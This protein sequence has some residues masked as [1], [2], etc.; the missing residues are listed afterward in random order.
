MS[1]LARLEKL[2]D[3]PARMTSDVAAIYMGISE[4]TSGRASARSA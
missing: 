4:S 3:W 2:P 1:A